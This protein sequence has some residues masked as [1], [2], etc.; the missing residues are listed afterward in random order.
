MWHQW[1]K[2]D[3]KISN[4]TDCWWAKSLTRYVQKWSEL[5]EASIARKEFIECG[6]KKVVKVAAS[7]RSNNF[8]V[9]SCVL[10]LGNV[11]DYKRGWGNF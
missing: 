11:D 3:R 2:K 8:I 9:P 6:C 5:P 1:Y 10:V 7:A 4:I